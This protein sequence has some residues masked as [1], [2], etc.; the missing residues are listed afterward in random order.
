MACRIGR[1]TVAMRR[2][3][4]GAIHVSLLAPRLDAAQ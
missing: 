4:A 1:M 2:N 3:V